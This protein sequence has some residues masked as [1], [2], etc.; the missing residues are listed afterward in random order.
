[1]S[2]PQRSRPVLLKPGLHPDGTVVPK[3]DPERSWT[4]LAVDESGHSGFR[5][6]GVVGLHGHQFIYR[7]SCCWGAAC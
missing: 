5:A 4:F 3:S 1:M 7:R 6:D 2:E